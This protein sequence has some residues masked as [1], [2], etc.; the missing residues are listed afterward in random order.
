[1]KESEPRNVRTRLLDS[2]LCKTDYSDDV[3][4]DIRTLADKYDDIITGILD[5]LASVARFTVR[6]RDH[7]PCFDDEPMSARRAVG[8]FIWMDSLPHLG[9]SYAA[10][11]KVLC[12]DRSCLLFTWPTSAASFKP[13]NCYI[14]ASLLCGRH[15]TVQKCTS[16]PNRKK[17]RISNHEAYG[18]FSTHELA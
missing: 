14:T 10:F 11:R 15:A 2:T 13:T 8:Q 1:M 7:H 6:E 5:E 3:T 12:L 18:R 4:N 16:S 17:V 9:T